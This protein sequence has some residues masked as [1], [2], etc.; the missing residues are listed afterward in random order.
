MEATRSNFGGLS[1]E[2]FINF[3]FILVTVFT[4]SSVFW[5]D[6]RDIAGYYQNLIIVSFSIASV[7][8][9]IYQEIKDNKVH[10]FIPPGPISFSYDLSILLIAMCCAMS[11]GI[12]SMADKSDFLGKHVHENRYWGICLV[13]FI[14]IIFVVF[15]GY[16]YPVLSDI[17]YK[18]KKIRY[19]QRPE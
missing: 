13:T 3:V 6:E 18:N 10:G 15:W 19:E 4:L 8:L 17:P 16:V 2:D 12:Y 1:T 9:H 5:S 14:P 11:I 7:I